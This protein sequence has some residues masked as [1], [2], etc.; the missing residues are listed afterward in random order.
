MIF[1]G[2]EVAGSTGLMSIYVIEFRRYKNS[3]LLEGGKFCLLA[4]FLLL[5]QRFVLPYSR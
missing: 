5:N 4:P 1:I 2:S 3:R